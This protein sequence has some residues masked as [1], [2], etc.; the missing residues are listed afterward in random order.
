MGTHTIDGGGGVSLHVTETGS[1]RP[2][3][4]VHGFSQS[5]LCWRKQ[6]DADLTD[7]CRLVAMDCRGHGDSEKPHDAYADSE[8][9]AEDVRAVIETL[10]LAD[11][12]MVGWSYGGLAVLD[13]VEAYG[14]DRLAG[15]SL[16]S[17]VASIGTEAATE[18]LGR[19][20]L[21][22]LPGFVS[23]DAAES[24][25]TMRAFVD[26]CVHEDLSPADRYYMLGYNVVVP[27]HVREGLRD[28][29][30]THETELAALD[31][32]VLVTHGTEDAVVLPEAA[33]RYVDLVDDAERS[34]YPETGHS[35]F[36]EAPDRFN[37]ELRAFVRGC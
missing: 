24:V 1:G 29:T 5:S 9:W 2:V 30:V 33:E 14:T 3:L 7:D 21:D 27:P 25:E 31:V 15:I 12:V 8:L 6:F 22:L 17:A 18:L 36:W 20:Y 37:R 4:F 11:V 13:Y 28:R 35:P 26:L 19:A 32:P 16:V 23:T 10:E 34:L